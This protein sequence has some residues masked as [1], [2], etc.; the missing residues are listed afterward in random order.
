MTAAERVDSNIEWPQLTNCGYSGLKLHSGQSL[1]NVLPPVIPSGMAEARHMSP[2]VDDCPKLPVL[3]E[4]KFNDIHDLGQP[5]LRL[6]HKCGSAKFSIAES[7]A[8]E[9]KINIEGAKQ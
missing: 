9:S 8:K 4:F 6:R 5:E 3:A 7:A 2:A 1:T